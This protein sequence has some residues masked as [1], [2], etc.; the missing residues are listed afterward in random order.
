MC[1]KKRL[2][3]VIDDDEPFRVALVELI[4]STAFDALG[5][6]SAEEFISSKH[7]DAYD[8]I[9]T[10][11]HLPGM[12]GIDLLRSLRSKQWSVPVILITAYMTPW[13]E[14]NLESIDPICLLMK[15]FSPDALTACIEKA[16]KDCQS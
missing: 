9:V 16:F 12:S 10:D 5:F 6:A 7:A 11:I 15:P 14:A 4:G 2:I 13:L 3:A 8:C 1:R